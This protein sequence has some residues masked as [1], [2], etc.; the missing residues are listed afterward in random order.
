MKMIVKNLQP[1][2]ITEDKGFKSFVHGL[3]PWYELSGRRVLTRIHLPSLYEQE[4]QKVGKELE[5][6]KD[7]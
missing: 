5:K 3:N 1:L 6:A 7:F 4:V 2:S